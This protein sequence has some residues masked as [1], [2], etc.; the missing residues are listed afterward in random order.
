MVSVSATFCVLSQLFL[1]FLTP[2]NHWYSWVIS[3]I[4]FPPWGHKKEENH[5]GSSSCNN[6]VHLKWP[7]LETTWMGVEKLVSLSW[8]NAINQ[9]S[10]CL[11]E[12]PAPNKTRLVSTFSSFISRCLWPVPIWRSSVILSQHGLC[13]SPSRWKIPLIS[14][15]ATGSTAQGL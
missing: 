9:S 4:S 2:N 14:L 13:L 8:R 11:S 7:V 15:F 3:M 5:Q 12:T 1:Y 10:K 6:N